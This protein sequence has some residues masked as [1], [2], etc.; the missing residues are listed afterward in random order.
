MLRGIPVYV[1]RCWIIAVSRLYCQLSSV[2]GLLARCDASLHATRSALLTRILILL[3]TL[4]VTAVVL[5]SCAGPRRIS[6]TAYRP[7]DYDVSLVK[8]IAVLRLNASSDDLARAVE[9]RMIENLTQLGYFSVVESDRVRPIRGTLNLDAAV[10]MGRRLGV[11]AVLIGDLEGEVSDQFTTET[12]TKKVLDYIKS[13]TE[14]ESQPVEETVKVRVKEKGEWVEKTKKVTVVKRV[15]KTREV[16]VY[17]QI[18]YTEKHLNRGGTLTATVQMVD[19]LTGAVLVSRSASHQE[20]HRRLFSSDE[21]QGATE[22]QRDSST[23]GWLS[24]VIEAVGTLAR[25]SRLSDTVPEKATIVANLA[26]RVSRKLADQ[27]S[28]RQISVVRLLQSDKATDRGV[29]F[30]RN[31]QWDQGGREWRKERD[32]NP[33]N[34]VAWNN[35]GIFYE[36]AGQY[37]E[38]KNAYEQALVQHPGNRMAQQNLSALK[39]MISALQ[40]QTASLGAKIEE[41]SL[42]LMV[43]SVLEGT[44]AE[45]LDLR[46]GD[47]ISHVNEVEVASVEDM[48]R[49]VVNGS[50]LGTDLS[51][52]ITRAGDN[53]TLR[54]SV[55]KVASRTVAIPRMSD[56]PR[57]KDV[58]VSPV[59]VDQVVTSKIN[60]PDALGVIMG[61]EDYRYAPSAP[62]ARHDALV[63]Y[64]YFIKSLGLKESNVY[65]RTDMD[66]TQAEF[67]KVFD[68][69]QGWL[70]RR[71]KPGKTEVFVYFIGHGI[72]DAATQ[73]AYLV[74]SDGD[75]NY[76]NTGYRLDEL[77]ANLNRVPAKQV[78]VMID[79]CFSGQVGRGTKVASLLAGAR[80]IAVQTRRVTLKPGIVV[81][82]AA[83]GNEVSSSYAEKSHGLFTYFVLKGLQG[84]ADQNGDSQLTVGELYNYVRTQVQGRAGFL[85][86]EQTP[87]FLGTDTGRVLVQY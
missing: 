56:S 85:D 75:P 51:L 59:D 25:E 19:V 1:N 58:T 12:N 33:A 87:E 64:E 6:F 69:D 18:T 23:G 20:R 15:P 40:K 50:R 14:Y 34:T 27:L 68:P 2:I 28:P 21:P 82:T 49:E 60:R 22:R 10:D 83:Q 67:R 79:A 70:A 31:G 13:V 53:L 5:F 66:A 35:L 55:N 57:N 46:K 9:S 77:Y 61:I 47:L 80:G 17:K 86:R 81:L 30:V 26:H 37:A 44:L 42:G 78:T 48:E 62:F 74:P 32:L 36:H 7:P 43:A 52:A 16:P 41:T 71:I 84:E 4:P 38:A 3:F 39:S 29:K 8:S 45:R 63:A 11:D 65:L 72:P 54:Y 73:D 24:S 76:P